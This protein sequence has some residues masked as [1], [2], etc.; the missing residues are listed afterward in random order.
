MLNIAMEQLT[1]IAALTWVWVA[2]F[3]VVGSRPEHGTFGQFGTRQ[4]CVR[5]LE[6]RRLEFQ[7]RGREIVGT[8]YYT[9]KKI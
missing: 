4:E 1:I 8:C 5:A 6:Q 7:Q 2:T 3:T 9:K